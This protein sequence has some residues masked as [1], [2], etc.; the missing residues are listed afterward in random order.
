[1]RQLW[2]F[3]IEQAKSCIFAVVIFSTLAI[4]QIIDVSFI[5]RY[6]FILIIC[7][8]TQVLML[9]TKRE[10]W[11]ELKVICV[12]HLI[13]LALEIYKVHMGS[14]SYPG[15]AISKIFGVPLYSGFMYASV[16]SYLCQ[17]WRRLDVTLEKWP[18]TWTVAILSAAIYFNFFTHHYIYDFRWVLKVATILLFLQT[19]VY[20]RVNHRTYKMPLVLSFVLI[21]FFI[22]IAEN[23]ATFF[24]AWQYPGQTASWQIVHLGK[25][26][27]WLLLVIV[28]FLIVA[29]L[30]HIKERSASY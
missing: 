20:Y 18:P 1:M 10:T 27:S 6:D 12:F 17:A 23:I 29:M 24:G 11:D 8:I 15:D 9:V 16:A 30:K 14:W 25:I 4:T 5:H 3:G 7:L 22:W 21:G 26:S 2:T 28:S 19:I 13:G